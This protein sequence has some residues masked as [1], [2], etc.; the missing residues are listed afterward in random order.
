MNGDGTPVGLEH[1]RTSGRFTNAIAAREVINGE[2]GNR[3]GGGELTGGFA[4][5]D[6]A[7]YRVAFEVRFRLARSISLS[8]SDADEQLSQQVSLAIC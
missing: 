8:I 7:G 4:D 2:T 6:L 5:H 3:V 1:F